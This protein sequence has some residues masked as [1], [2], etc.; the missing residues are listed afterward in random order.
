MN[1]LREKKQE[2]VRNLNRTAIYD[3]AL[4][5]LKKH[6][7]DGFTMQQ[8]AEKAGMAIGTLYNS[9]TSKEQIVNYLKDSLFEEFINSLTT[10]TRQGSSMEKIQMCAECIFGF[11]TEDRSIIN[12]LRQR[13]SGNDR[14]QKLDII[15]KLFGDIIEKGIAAGEFKHVDSRKSALYIFSFLVGYDDHVCENPDFDPVVESKNAMEFL[16]PYLVG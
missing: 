4:E 5:L 10:A 1:N 8:V 2:V 15:M 16:K 14:Q 12:M 13:V 11:R 3:A 7:L 9:F 6:G